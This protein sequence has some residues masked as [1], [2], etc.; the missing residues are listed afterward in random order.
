M[1]TGYPYDGFSGGGLPQ[2]RGSLISR[3]LPKDGN[4]SWK[5]TTQPL[6]EPVT[7]DEVKLFSSI[8]AVEHDI[9]I[10]GFIEAV[11]IAAEEYLGRA[12]VSQTITSVLDFWPGE[13]VELPKPPLI[14]V[15][16]IVTVDEDDAETTYSSSNYYLNTT[17]EPG[18]IIIKRN[19]T[20]PVNTARDYGRFIIRS[21]HGYGPDESDVPRAIKEGI[22]L[23]VAVVY[24]TRVL[25][26]KNPPPEVKVFF[27]GLFKIPTVMIR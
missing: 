13:I 11:R 12:F 9:L 5:V 21:K 20:W 25:D 24:A 8:D 17:A 4:R 23:W 6:V 2:K 14:S 10:R 16:E 7:V 22:I 27:D 3:E 19:V 26:S 1:Y 18:Q 15:T